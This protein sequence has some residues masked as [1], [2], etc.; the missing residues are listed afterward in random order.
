MTTTN[1]E[2]L[3]AAAFGMQLTDCDVIY[4]CADECMHWHAF[5][6]YND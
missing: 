5:V 6:V 3:R 2:H 1:N 4:T